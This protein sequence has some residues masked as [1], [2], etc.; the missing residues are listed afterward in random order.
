MFGGGE[1]SAESGWAGNRRG[2]GNLARKML[3][4]EANAGGYRSIL[5]LVR[6]AREPGPVLRPTA[7]TARRTNSGQS[8]QGVWM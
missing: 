1:S 8:S 2:A 4:R 7:H 3:P 5:S 6:G